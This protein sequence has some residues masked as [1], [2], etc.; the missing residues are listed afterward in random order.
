MT[1]EFPVHSR[2]AD[3]PTFEVS[4]AADECKPSIISRLFLVFIEFILS[5]VSKRWYLTHC[6]VIK[7]D[8]KDGEKPLVYFQSVETPQQ[9]PAAWSDKNGVPAPP[10]TPFH[11]DIAPLRVSCNPPAV[12]HFLMLSI[13]LSSSEAAFRG[14]WLTVTLGSPRIPLSSTS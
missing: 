8:Y 6:R 1:T 7:Q 13:L 5:P 11:V 12:F 9:I 2:L 10:E 4:E 14:L 3:D